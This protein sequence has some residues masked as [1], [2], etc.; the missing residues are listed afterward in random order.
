MEND[1]HV[2]EI[3]CWCC[4]KE[5][6]KV[7]DKASIAKFNIERELEGK[8]QQHNSHNLSWTKIKKIEPKENKNMK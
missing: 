7:G 3:E 6:R 4:E 2:K 1:G 5:N 8:I